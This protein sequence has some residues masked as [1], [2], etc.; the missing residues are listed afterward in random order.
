MNCHVPPQFRKAVEVCSIS[1]L[2]VMDRGIK[3]PVADSPGNGAGSGV[4]KKRNQ[5]G[6]NPESEEIT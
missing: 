6:N 2:P 1:V 5:K 4:D 3:I